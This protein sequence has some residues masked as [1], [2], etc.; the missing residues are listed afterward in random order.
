[1]RFT[2]DEAAIK[3]SNC[4]GRS[5]EFGVYRFSFPPFRTSSMLLTIITA[6]I[7]APSAKAPAERAYVWQPALTLTDSVV[8]SEL[9]PRL[10]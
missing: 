5:S 1:M 2:H 9:T 6:L 3:S 4:L 7:N 8:V 10:F